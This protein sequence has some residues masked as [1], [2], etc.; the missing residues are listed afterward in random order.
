MQKRSLFLALVAGV[1]LSGF[2]ALAA[3]ADT[4]TLADLI[5]PPPTTITNGD[6]VF[7][8]F[9]YTGPAPPSA[10]QVNVTTVGTPPL[11]AGELGLS[12]TP[13]FP[14]HVFAGMSNTWTISYDVH[15][16]DPNLFINDAFLGI[17]AFVLK[18]GGSVNVT[19]SISTL[20]GTPLGTLSASVVDNTTRTASDSIF[21]SALAQDIHVTKTFELVAIDTPV[22][23]TEVDQGFSQIASVPEPT[24]L[25]LLGIGMTGFFA[26]RRFFKRTTVA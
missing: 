12:F 17:T 16:T 15:V 26:F 23:L 25:A 4:V 21:L 13:T 5:G 22:Y 7:S 14:W 9:A 18:G 20:G 11:P 24:S 2:G 19:E 6:K 10:A 8:D 3:R 1:L